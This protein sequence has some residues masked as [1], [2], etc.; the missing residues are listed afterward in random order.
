VAEFAHVIV[1]RFNLPSAGAESLIRAKEGWLRDRVALFER[2]CLPSVLAQSNQFFDWIIYFDP[3]S[4]GWL[5]ERIDS[6]T[7]KRSYIPLFR[8][9][10]G[11]ADLAADIDE[12]TGRRGTALITSSLDNDDALAIDFIERLQAAAALRP[13]RTAVYLSRGLIKS[14]RRV[15]LRVDPA[16]AFPSVVEDWSSPVTCWADWHN[17]LGNH[18]P[19]L[20]LHGDPGWLQVIHGANVSNRVRGRLARPGDYTR[21]FPTALD[22]VETPSPA[23]EVAD[24]LAAR[25]WR[26]ARD[27][28]RLLTKAAIM[29]LV[30]KDGLDRLKHIAALRGDQGAAR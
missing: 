27:S 11:P 30:G 3:K 13:G 5:R 16:N 7:E 23:E 15:Y 10:V 4:P 14:G 28:G 17:L 25:P 24:L 18:M 1:T 8:T 19:V 12:I 29:Q 26:L 9:S 6:H 22:G 20:E 21:L 2:Y